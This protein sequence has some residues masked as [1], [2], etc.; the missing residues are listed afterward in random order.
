M[1][2]VGDVVEVDAQAHHRGLVRN[3]VDTHDCS[4]DR[5]RV[6]DVAPDVL[7]PFVAPVGDTAVSGGEE[8]VE[9]T[10]LVATVDQRVHDVGT[11]EAGSPGYEHAHQART[12]GRRMVKIAPSASLATSN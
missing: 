4:R 12:R 5:L 11:D 3:R 9:D 1:D 7:G 10:N 6:G 2:V 8:R